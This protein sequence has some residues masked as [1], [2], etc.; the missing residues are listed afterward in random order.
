MGRSRLGSATALCLLLGTAWP[1]R[2]VA[3]SWHDPNFPYVAKWKQYHKGSSKIGLGTAQLIHPRWI[4]TAY[5][6]AKFKHQNPNAGST[7]IVFQGGR[8]RNVVEVYKAPGVDIALAKLNRPIYAVEPVALLKQ[9]FRSSDGVVDFT[10]AGRSGG[11]HYH[12]VR[13]ESR[14][15]GKSF[16]WAARAFASLAIRPARPATAAGS[17]ASSDTATCP[18]C[19]SP[20]CMAG[21]SL[22]RSAPSPTGSTGLSAPAR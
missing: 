10:I 19:S 12:R 17:G 6:V 13:G 15:G 4:I 5:H 21:E 3:D 20:C 14:L 11:L 8:T 9:P 7:E 16:H 2:L 22:R 18:T 1:C